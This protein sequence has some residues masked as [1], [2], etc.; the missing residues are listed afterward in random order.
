MSFK[1]QVQFAGVDLKRPSSPH[2][3]WLRTSLL[4]VLL[5]L[6][7]LAYWQYL[8]HLMHPRQ[9]VAAHV[10]PAAANPAATA[11]PTH[12]PMPAKTP[13]AQHTALPPILKKV[14]DDSIVAVGN[15]LLNAVKISPAAP[16]A[17]AAPKVPASTPASST[18]AMTAV[19]EPLVA[20]IRAP[21]APRP[22]RVHTD[23]ERL[24]MAAQTAFA[25]VVDLAGKYPDSYGFQAGDFLS[26]AKLGEPISVYTIDENDRASYQA[27]Q[28]V[29][30]LLK[31]APQWVFPVLMGDRICCMV[32][33]RRN[34]HEF[35]PGPGSKSLAMAWDK[36][37]EKWPADKGYHPLLVVNPNIPGYYFT[38]PELPVQNITDTVQMFLMHP[39]PS[40]ADVILTSWR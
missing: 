19:A 36:I 16:V 15:Y 20:T 9:P 13:A 34:G 10:V 32:S 7:A 31:L 38:V 3:K 18:P 17:I 2:R 6:A 11:N 4:T 40:P 24:L 22:Y 27:G 33:V 14:A 30:P 8:N 21:A 26:D 29:Q 12:P 25:N 39:S 35:V 28:P 23:H 37:L 1:F 5:V